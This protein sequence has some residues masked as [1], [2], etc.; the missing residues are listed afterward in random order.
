M[1]RGVGGNSGVW[2]GMESYSSTRP[3][4]VGNKGAAGVGGPEG[5]EGASGASDFGQTLT[6]A[7]ESVEQ[8]QANADSSIYRVATGQDADL[9]GMM[10]ALEEANI[11]LRTMASVRDKVVEAYQAIWNMP[12]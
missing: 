6:Q 7:V 10:I 5:A 11:S 1:V 8:T 2:T 9:H 3:G 12:V 4:G